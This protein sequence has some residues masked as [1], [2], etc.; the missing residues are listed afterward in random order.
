MDGLSVNIPILPFVRLIGGMT[1]SGRSGAEVKLRL[2]RVKRGEVGKSAFPFKAK[3][4]DEI[5][6]R[7]SSRL[8]H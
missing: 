3:L 7:R 4:D 2:L 6:E 5:V 1:V 8:I